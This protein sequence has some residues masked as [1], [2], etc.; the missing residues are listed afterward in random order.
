MGGQDTGK[1]T[2]VKS[3]VT[4]KEEAATRQG[5][6]LGAQ[7]G[8]KQKQAYIPEETQS[9]I[10]NISWAKKVLAVGTGGGER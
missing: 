4:P 5:R 10:I 2:A 6:L 3:T 7:K 8:N 9:V 1:D